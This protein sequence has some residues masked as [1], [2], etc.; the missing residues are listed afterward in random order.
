MGKIFTSQK[1][2]SFLELLIAVTLS[3]IIGLVVISLINQV[4]LRGKGGEQAF[5]A[6]NEAQSSM[7]KMA[8]EIRQASKLTAADSQTTT[9]LMYKQV[10]D[11]APTQVRYYLSGNNLNRGETPPGGSGPNYTYDPSTEVIKPVATSVIN[12]ASAI[13]SYFDQYGNVLL[14]PINLA[15][16]TLVQINLTIRQT[17]NPSPFK[18]ETKVQLRFNK[19]NL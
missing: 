12:G 4:L 15:Q 17:N 5:N 1:G 10:S 18:V 19:T 14:A 13:F 6:Q 9:F 16:V 11:S 3:A 2:F 8:K 7:N